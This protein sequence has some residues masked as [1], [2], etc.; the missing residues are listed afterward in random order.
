MGK[1]YFI[2][3]FCLLTSSVIAQTAAFR[4]K[5]TGQISDNNQKVVEFA[6][7]TLHKATDSTL[8]K[9]A[10]SDERGLFEFEEVGEGR[11][12]VQVSQVGYQR[13]RTPLF[14]LNADN[15]TIRLANIQVQEE[16]RTLNEVNVR[17]AKPF[18]ERQLD[19]IIVNVENSIVSAGAAAMDVLERAPGIRV[20]QDGR[21]SLKGKQGV[22]IMIDG[23]PSQLA[24]SD[25]DNYLRSLPSNAIDKIE[26]ITNP[27]ARYDAAGNAGIIN[28]R[29][30]KDQRL[31]MNGNLTA[32]YGSGRYGKANAGFSLNYRNKKWNYFGN[33]NYSYRKAFTHLI[34]NRRYFTGNEVAERQVLDNYLKFPFKTHTVR[35]GMDFFA[36][37]KTTVGLLLNGVSNAFSPNGFNETFR[38]APT[39]ALRDRY[40]TQ[41]NSSDLWQNGSVNLNFKHT[42]D[43]T[44]N[45]GSGRELTADLDYVRYQSS[46]DQLFTTNLYNITTNAL[47]AR[48]L[49][50][51]D[52]GGHINIRSLKADYVNPL[53]NKG[54]LEAGFKLS[55]VT[56]DNDV[57][58]YDRLDNRDVLNTNMSNHFVYEEN[59]NAAYANVNRPVGKLTMQFGLRGEQ[60]LAKGRQLTTGQTFDRNYFQL[61]PSLA[62]TQKLTKNHELNYTLSRRIDRPSYRQLNPFR[63]FINRTTYSEGNPY[64]LP[65]LTYAAEVSHTYKQRFTTT[66]SYSRTTNNITNVLLRQTGNFGGSRDTLVTFQ[67]DRNIANFEYLGLTVSA[68]AQ[69]TKWWNTNAN[70]TAYYGKYTGNLGNTNIRNALPTF[71]LNVTNSFT[72]PKG[73]TAEL[74][75]FYQAK[76]V[77]GI[78]TIQRLGSVSAG[79]QA[80]VLQR[81]G[82]LRLNV[83][84]VFL[85]SIVNGASA[86]AG[87][88]E[89]FWQRRDSRV[90]TLAF[91]Y[92]FGKGTVAPA[93]RRSTGSESEQRRVQMGS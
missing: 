38:Y 69:L 49:L 68:P 11:Y 40:T 43:S 83:S 23:K 7:V 2:L 14:Q 36:T 34:I 79:L 72:L 82:T 45:G 39:G 4:G 52:L 25:L 76:E 85:T 26:I 8:V 59:I 88:D 13:F 55:Y 17:T 41:N 53:K 16:T 37:K 42:F 5:I 47:L 70:L 61:F 89:K 66:V 63:F 28:I 35:A 87:V 93:R 90:G 9:G 27:S 15:P 81:K 91:T 24:A 6:T 30:K 33:Y 12:Y 58:F 48:E 84:D 50:I 57:R 29:M 3:F 51:G 19:K 77:Y 73:L 44:G 60:T 56:T 86:A 54:R 46:T 78:M 62:V 64:L 80:P 1:R 65:Q 75:G 74:T 20:D 22:I 67:T 32:S 18:V 10:L 31:G 71:N 21:I 92:R